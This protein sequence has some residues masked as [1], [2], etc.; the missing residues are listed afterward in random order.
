MI[1]YVDPEGEDT[2]KVRKRVDPRRRS[3]KIARRR[4][5]NAALPADEAMESAREY[6]LRVLDRSA[7]SKGTLQRK[8]TQR[9]YTESVVDTLLNRFEEVGLLDDWAYARALVRSRH[10]E[11]GLVGRALRQELYKKHL[12]AD[13]IDAVMEETTSSQDPAQTAFELACSKARRSTKLTDEVRK[14][15]IIGFLQR[16]GYSPGVCFEAT[17]KALA[18]YPSEVD[19]DYE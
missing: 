8:L 18:E 1:R 19:C 4:E 7:C 9:G 3:E 11:R 16:K 14:R 13:I 15:R 5:K 6:A 12:P 10:L 17:T 2:S